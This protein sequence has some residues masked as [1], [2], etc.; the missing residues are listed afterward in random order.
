[1]KIRVLHILQAEG[2]FIFIK[3]GS[4]IFMSAE[5]KVARYLVIAEFRVTLN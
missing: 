4:F 2:S 5:T 3:A 1:M